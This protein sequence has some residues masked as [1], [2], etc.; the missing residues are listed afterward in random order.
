VKSAI[1]IADSTCPGCGARFDGPTHAYMTSSPACWSAYNEILGREFQDTAYFSIHHL[2][3]DAYAVQHPGDPADRRAVQSVNIHLASLYVVFELNRDFPATRHA[4]K[5]LANDFNDEFRPLKPPVVY[6]MT[7]KD[8][9]AAQTAEEHGRLVRQ[10]AEA[11]LARMVRSSR[12]RARM[13]AADRHVREATITFIDTIEPEHAQGRL[14]TI[15]DRIKSPDGRVDNILQAHSLRP[16]SLEGHMALYKNVLHHRANTT[17]KWFLETIGVYVSLINKCAYCVDHHF[18]GLLR[19]LQDDDKARAIKYA[20]ETAAGEGAPKTEHLTPKESAA[21][22]Y[23]GRLSRDPSSIHESS[24]EALRRAGWE[25][26]E[27]LEINQVAAYFAYANRTVLGLGVTA[28]G[29]ILGLSP[30][31]DDWRHR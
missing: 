17:P 8:I 3:V 18:E 1:A 26:G 19:V 11:V 15:Y 16:A 27:I 31:E 10:W 6:D 12:C 5:M 22:D 29:D 23:A 21:L 13:G 24:V 7:V 30:G 4:L 20:L 2:S 14:K 9:P 25:D 28:E